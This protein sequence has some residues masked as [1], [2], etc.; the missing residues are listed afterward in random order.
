MPLQMI[1]RETRAPLPSVEAVD[2]ELRDL[3]DRDLEWAAEDAP[4]NPQGLLTLAEWRGVRARNEQARRKRQAEKQAAEQ[5]KAATAQAERDQQNA[6][7]LD[8]YRQEARRAF[9]GTDEQF[10][11]LWPELR[12]RWLLDQTR[13]ALSDDQALVEQKRREIGGI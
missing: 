11:R 1:D 5:A 10:S 3:P 8:T 9:P 4:A 6:A 13:A 7:A 2:R 12:D